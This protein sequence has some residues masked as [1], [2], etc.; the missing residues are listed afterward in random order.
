MRKIPDW[1]IDQPFLS[2]YCNS[3]H[4]FILIIG[5]SGSGKTSIATLLNKQ[6]NFS[7]IRNLTTR[8]RRSTD[9]DGH[10]SY[11][12]NSEYHKV[13]EDKKFAFGRSKSSSK[14]GYLKKD[15]LTSIDNSKHPI[16]MF[17]NSGAEYFIKQF[18][19][20]ILVY[21]TADPMKIVDHCQA[22]PKLS[23]DETKIKLESNS[24]LFNRSI[25]DGIPSLM[26]KNNYH[27]EKELIE[28]TNQLLEFIKNIS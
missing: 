20:A 24:I 15:I 19:N 16:I 3:D 17:R 22:K 5:P 7:I 12:S 25:K 1:H 2:K 27:G 13:F 18:R 11:I 6:T 8:A 28:L 23:L 26:L 10:F 21:L 4:K 9:P 14:Y